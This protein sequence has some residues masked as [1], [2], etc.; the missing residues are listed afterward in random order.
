MIK[1]I[2]RMLIDVPYGVLGYQITKI[3][4]KAAIIKGE[5]IYKGS[6]VEVKR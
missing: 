3:G 6:Q 5:P 1:I 2:D 4:A